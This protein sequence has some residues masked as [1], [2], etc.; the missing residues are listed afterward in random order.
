MSMEWENNNST[1]DPKNKTY[2]LHFFYEESSLYVHSEWAAKAYKKTIS[3]QDHQHISLC[4]F[5]IVP[6]SPNRGM[7]VYPPE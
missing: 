6:F 7:L 3:P 2:L 5:Q 1:V 4:S